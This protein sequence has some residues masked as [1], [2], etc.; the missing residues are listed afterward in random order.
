[1]ASAAGTIAVRTNWERIS[2]DRVF[3]VLAGVFVLLV[4]AY[5][6]L[7]SAR[8]L[9][10]AELARLFTA[11]NLEPTRNTLLA[12]LLTLP[13]SVAIAVPMAWLCTRTNLPW[14]RAI[15]GLVGTSFVMP[16][17]F[18]S[19]AYVILFGEN[20]GLINVLFRDL[21]GGPLFNIFSFSGVVFVAVLQ[22]YPLIFFTTASGLTKMNTELEESARIAGLSNFKIFFRITLA[23]ILP[24]IMAGVAFSFATALTMLSGPLIL[25]VS[26]GIPFLTSEMFA[27][28]V[29]NPNINRA[30]AL[31]LPLLMMTVAALWVQARMLHGESERFAVVS[32]KGQRSEILDLGPWRVPLLFLCLFP[33]LFSLVL[34][35]LTLLGAGLTQNW[36]KGLVF[37]NLTLQNFRDLFA[38]PITLKA[39][40]N[41]LVLSAGVGIFLALAGSALAA[42]L[43]GPQTVI[44]RVIR[45]IGLVPLGIAHVVAGV[46]VILTWYGRPFHLGGTLLI[47][48]LGYV[49]VMLPYALKVCEAAHGQV[50]ASLTD[51]ARISGC[52]PLGSW[53][54]VLFPL[55]RNGIFTTFVLVFL[56][57]VKEFPL[58]AMVYNSDTVTLAVRVYNYFEGGNYEATGAAAVLLLVITFVV[59]A[60]AGR[61]F[62]IDMSGMRV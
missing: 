54:H 7:M 11:R 38:S 26:V 10:L 58:T 28:I 53:R 59:L 31:S 24:S 56:F 34:P 9:T 14:R 60:L 57:C 32:G 16:M 22:C 50:D 20:A 41:T 44:K 25:A 2:V 1:M 35:F 51:A 43:A 37:D 4:V 55:M 6:I 27:A 3:L 30:V 40:G 62:R 52:S 36:W 23:V 19:I 17:L 29:M 33:L 18:T 8:A 5:P 42:V 45:G 47:L 39:L 48:A 12:A 49:L 21:L 61:F 46:L 15:V 13:P